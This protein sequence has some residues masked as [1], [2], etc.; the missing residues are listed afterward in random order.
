MLVA[1]ALSLVN[2]APLRLRR[3][4][5]VRQ[6]GLLHARSRRCRAAW[7]PHLTRAHSVIIAATEATARRRSV[8]V[9]GSGLLDDVPL[10][11]LADL[12]N[13]VILID[14]VHPWPARLAAR[15]HHNVALVTA[16]ISAGLTDPGLLEICTAA[17]LI[18]S[19]N[20]LSQLPIVPIEAYEARG[21]E[22]PP[23]LGTQLIE[24]HLAALDRLAAGTGR[25]C[26]IT[27][28]VQRAEDR[29]G[30]VTDSLDLMLG[31]SLPPPS[32]TWD[33][34]IAPFGE[35]GRRHRLIHRVHA[36]PDWRTARA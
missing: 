12:F 19:A 16:E 14:A 33:W 30:R 7:A 23:E 27:D 3:L 25:V 6:S 20:L 18:V 35:I 24:T 10:D 32:Q 13:R 29:A 17:D 31:V 9:L 26:L 21:R 34:E 2:P 1:W 11:A 5:Y 22:A 8:V 4:G 28:T 36:Y 15:R